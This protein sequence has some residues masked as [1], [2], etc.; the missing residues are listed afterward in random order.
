M[1]QPG[2]GAAAEPQSNRE[3]AAKLGGQNRRPGA[4]LTPGQDGRTHQDVGRR[5]ERPS[6]KTPAAS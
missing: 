5:E 3:A 1:V 2:V 6:E 4:D